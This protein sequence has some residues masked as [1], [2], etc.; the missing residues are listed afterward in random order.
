M[1]R[2]LTTAT[3]GLFLVLGLAGGF[4]RPGD[5]QALA[6]VAHEKTI[7]LGVENMFCD[8][9]PLIVRK[10]L[11]SV[12]GV[13]KATVSFKDKTAVVTYDDTKTTVAA[14]VKATTDAGYPSAPKN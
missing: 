5:N 2:V 9:C 14:L 6:Q 3:L 8:A 12:P 10:S 13:A 7:K 1:T 4:L 11:E